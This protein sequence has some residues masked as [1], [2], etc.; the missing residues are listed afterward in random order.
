M[1]PRLF[2]LGGMWFCESAAIPASPGY[3]LQDAYENWYWQDVIRAVYLICPS[4]F[5]AEGET[6]Q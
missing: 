1:K 6:I 2:M 4:A 3:T 5:G